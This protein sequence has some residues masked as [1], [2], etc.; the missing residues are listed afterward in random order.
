M[1]MFIFVVVD[2]CIIGNVIVKFDKREDESHLTMTL[3]LDVSLA[4]GLSTILPHIA[5]I[6]IPVCLH[7]LY[8]VYSQ[9]K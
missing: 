2:V 6:S 8:N 3:T 5:I 7:L 1:L 9:T 4:N